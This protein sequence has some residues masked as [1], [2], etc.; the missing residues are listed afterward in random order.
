MS[1]P[2]SLVV[3]TLVLDL[4]ILL[5]LPFLGAR[6]PDLATMPRPL[7][8]WQSLWALLELKLTVPTL[9]L[10]WHIAPCLTQILLTSWL[11]GKLQLVSPTALPTSSSLL[12]LPSFASKASMAPT[13]LPGLGLFGGLSLTMRESGICSRFLILILWLP[14][15]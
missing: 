13:A 6:G 8:S 11:I 1:S 10:P 5:L 7:S 15:P 2:A 3:T 14:A 4:S 9:D 12:P